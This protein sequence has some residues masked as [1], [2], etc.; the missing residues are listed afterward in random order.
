M[1][2]CLDVYQRFN[3]N[4][5]SDYMTVWNL[6]MNRCFQHWLIRCFA[7]SIWLFKTYR[8]TDVWM[9]TNDSMRFS[10]QIT[11][12]FK[13]SR[14]TD[15]FP[16]LTQEKIIEAVNV[17][18]QSPHFGH[19]FDYSK[20]LGDITR[21]EQT[22]QIAIVTSLQ[23]NHSIKYSAALHACTFSKQS[24]QNTTSHIQILWHNSP[25]HFLL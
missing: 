11:W 5:Y 25:F 15:V 13:T 3:D 2:R 21:D 19:N 1:N 18:K 17:I 20:L 9:F 10:T 23:G 8:W 4:I 7:Q 22:G 24:P 6:Q 16:G 12:L 14:W